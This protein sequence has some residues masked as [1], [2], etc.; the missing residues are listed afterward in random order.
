MNGSTCCI[1]KDGTIPG[2]KDTRGGIPGG[3]GGG[4]A[5]AGAGAGGNPGGRD[6]PPGIALNPSI[7]MYSPGRGKG[8]PC[9]C[10]G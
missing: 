8:W 2:C 9:C 1:G 3:G 5:G 4:G 10:C 7:W 6:I